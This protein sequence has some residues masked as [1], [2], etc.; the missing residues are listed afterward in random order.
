MT[1][2]LDNSQESF[3]NDLTWNK[4]KLSYNQFKF[5]NLYNIHFGSI[6]I[7]KEPKSYI[8]ENY[9]KVIILFSI[10]RFIVFCMP[11]LTDLSHDRSM[12]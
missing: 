10:F 3:F 9:S 4:H 7:I 12:K 6:F 11:Y 1:C 5:Q 2:R 8:F